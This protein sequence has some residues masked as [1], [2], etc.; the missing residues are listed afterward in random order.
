MKKLFFIGAVAL[1]LACHSASAQ[2]MDQMYMQMQA[3]SNQMLQQM[4]NQIQQGDMVMQ[5]ALEARQRGDYQTSSY[6]MVKYYVDNHRRMYNDYT[7][8]DNVLFQRYAQYMASPQALQEIRATGEASRRWSQDWNQTMQQNNTRFNEALDG[9]GYYR[10]PY[11]GN[12]YYLQTDHQ[13]PY[14]LNPDGS[15]SEGIY[16]DP[17]QR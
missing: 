15:Y 11:D 8:P 4:Q 1:G 7:T 2:S 16:I 3:D 6:I 10:N 12:G 13:T 17:S 14:Y 9:S 5:Q